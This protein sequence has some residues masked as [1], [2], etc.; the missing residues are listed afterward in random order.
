MCQVEKLPE[1]KIILLKIKSAGKIPRALKNMT[2]HIK[3]GSYLVP[4]SLK[5]FCS[6]QCLQAVESCFK[7][8][9]VKL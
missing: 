9:Y 5:R 2:P 3:R 7:L 4:H 8:C 1:N 6:L